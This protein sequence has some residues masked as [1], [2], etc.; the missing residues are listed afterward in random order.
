MISSILGMA[1][2]LPQGSGP[3]AEREREI[4]ILSRI[5][6]HLAGD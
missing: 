3:F 6:R 1:Q 4:E 2:G 5:E